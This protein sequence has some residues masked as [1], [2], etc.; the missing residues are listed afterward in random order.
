MAG[1]V[2]CELDVRGYVGNYIVA[3]R[4]GMG[5]DFSDIF[6]VVWRVLAFSAV[7]VEIVKL[8]KRHQGLSRL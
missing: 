6:L 5:H 7:N 8:M 1:V 2:K 3:E 4:Y